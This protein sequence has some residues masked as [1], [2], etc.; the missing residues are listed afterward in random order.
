M[1][2]FSELIYN[3]GEMLNP[4]FLEPKDKITQPNLLMKK[5]CAE[6][7]ANLFNTFFLKLELNFNW[8]QIYRRFERQKKGKGLNPHGC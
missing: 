2:I 1:P 4:Y 5:K 6:V 8:Q 3:L 7:I